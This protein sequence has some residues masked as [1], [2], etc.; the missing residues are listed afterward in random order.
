[1]ATHIS[2][3]VAFS[4]QFLFPTAFPPLSRSWPRSWWLVSF[5]ADLSPFPDSPSISLRRRLSIKVFFVAAPVVFVF[6]LLLLCNNLLL[7]RSLGCSTIT[8]YVLI[9]VVTHF[10]A[11]I[12]LDNLKPRMIITNNVYKSLIK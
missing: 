12:G 1:M 3:E 11:L 2:V 6:I 9:L 4:N 5:P 10:L 8:S 7:L